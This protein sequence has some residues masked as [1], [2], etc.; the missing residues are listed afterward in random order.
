MVVRADLPHE[1]AVNQHRK[2]LIALADEHGCTKVREHA[3]EHQQGAGQHGGHYQGDDDLH[4]SLECG[5]AKAFGCLVQGIVQVFQGAGYVHVHQGEGLEGEYQYNARKPIDAAQ[6]YVKEAVEYLGE[7]AV[8]PQQ[9][10]PC[11]G[12]Y[13][14][15]GQVGNDN[16]DVQVFTSFDLYAPQHVGHGQPQ[17]GS[18]HGGYNGNLKAVYQGAPVVFSCEEFSKIGKA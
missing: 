5:A 1:L 16:Q 3:H 10:N 13:E 4:H 14:R 17:N 12:P 15:R 18:H 11:I 7:E 6:L 8:A 2:G 9:L